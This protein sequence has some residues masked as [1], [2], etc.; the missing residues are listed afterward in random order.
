MSSVI[1]EKC[2]RNYNDKIKIRD[3]YI[4]M[5]MIKTFSALNNIIRRKL[6]YYGIY[7]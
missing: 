7:V 5:Y 1:I 6:K 3:M 4:L 2:I